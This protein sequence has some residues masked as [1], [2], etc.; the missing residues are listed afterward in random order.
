MAHRVD[1][2]RDLD[3]YVCREGQEYVHAIAGAAT[4]LFERHRPV[5]P[6]TGESACFDSAQPHLCLPRGEQDARIPV[7][8]AGPDTAAKLLQKYGETP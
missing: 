3:C 2:P 4:I 6:A 1:H 5:H 8:C 7:V